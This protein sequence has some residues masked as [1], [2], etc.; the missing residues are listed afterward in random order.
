MANKNPEVFSRIFSFSNHLNITFFIL[1]YLGG[2]LLNQLYWT[3]CSIS[4]VT[5]LSVCYHTWVQYCQTAQDKIRRL[6]CFE[7]KICYWRCFVWISYTTFR[8]CS[9]L[10]TKICHS[11]YWIVFRLSK[12]K[13]ML[14]YYLIISF[15]AVSIPAFIWSMFV[16]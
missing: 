14:F 2:L 10:V 15:R 4:S 16:L 6:K 9:S 11:M 1:W 12:K 5:R 13:L 8:S 7:A 3:K